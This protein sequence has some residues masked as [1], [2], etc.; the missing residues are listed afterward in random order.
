MSTR[1][2]FLLVPVWKFHRNI[3]KY[4]IDSDQTCSKLMYRVATP[5]GNPI[6]IP[7]IKNA[8][9]PDWGLF[10]LPKQFKLQF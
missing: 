1:T 4:S 6:L 9:G 7:T 3:L 2:F 8:L 10:R 5:I